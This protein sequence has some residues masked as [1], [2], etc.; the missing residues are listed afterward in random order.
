MVTMLAAR[1]LFHLL[2]P[3]IFWLIAVALATRL[4]LSEGR[5]SKEAEDTIARIL[6][7]NGNQI[8]QTNQNT[9]SNKANCDTTCVSAKKV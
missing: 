8:T 6:I 9:T 1:H 2:V 3:C 7:L 4:R 5:L